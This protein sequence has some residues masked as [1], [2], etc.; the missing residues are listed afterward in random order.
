MR[1]LLDESLPRSLIRHLS[2]VAAETVFDRG[3]AGL[4][5]GRLLT[6]AAADFDVFITADQNLQYQQ[7]LR[8]HRIGVVVVSAVT[9]RLAD[10]QPLVPAVLEACREV[11]PG[12]VRLVRSSSPSG[13]A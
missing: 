3:W 8:N 12:E 6:V 7:N 9:N 13:A 11:R 1:V 10:L 4:T 5:N 2:G